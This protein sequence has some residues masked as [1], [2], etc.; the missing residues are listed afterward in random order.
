MEYP[1]G[2]EWT[3]IPK[4]TGGSTSTYYCDYFVTHDS[5]EENLVLAGANWADASNA[6]LAYWNCNNVASH[7]WSVIGARLSYAQQ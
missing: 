4:S 5:G 1:V 6:G 2:L 3:F 7:V